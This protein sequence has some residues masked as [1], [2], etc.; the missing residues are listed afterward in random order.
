MANKKLKKLLTL[1]DLEN[2]YS[3]RKKS[4]HFSASDEAEAIV[5]QVP[6]TVTFSEDEYDKLN[7]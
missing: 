1:Q 4:F 7:I 5:V 2:F 3:N 6:G